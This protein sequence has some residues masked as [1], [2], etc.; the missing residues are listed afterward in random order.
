MKIALAHFRIGETDGVSLEMDKWKDVLTRMGHEVVFLA[1]SEG[2]NRAHVI[3]ELRYKH[4]LNEKF[5]YNAFEKLVDYESANDFAEDVLAFSRAIETKLTDF[6]EAEGIH[7]LVPF[8]IWSL[9]WSLP[10]GIAFA[11][12]VKTTGIR[13]LAYHHDFYWEREKYAK[14]TCS[15]VTGWLEEYF[16]PD[17][18]NVRHV[19]INRLA[20]E[21]LYRRRSIEAAVIPNVF[22]FNHPVWAE[23]EYNQSL[24]D[25]IGAS[26]DDIVIL[27]ATR[28]MERKAIELGID[29]VA[30]LQ[31]E[32]D[33]RK[34]QSASLY[35]GKKLKDE[36]RI[37]YVLAGMPESTYEYTEQLR[38]KAESLRVDLR[39]INHLIDYSRTHANGSK[40]YSLWD[41]Y[42]AADFVTYPSILE[43]WGNQLLEAVFANKPMLIYEYPVYENDIRH[44]GFRFVSLGNTHRTNADGLVSVGEEKIKAAAVRMADLLTDGEQYRS[45]VQHNFQIGKTHFSYESLLA[46]LQRIL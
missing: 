22:D 39:F 10:A 34:A 24:R 26:A 32:L 12:A 7:L 21:E 46:H 44:Y 8:N 28:V 33:A 17:L 42:V 16:P 15:F 31:K 19:V 23:D 36:S 27:Q 11:R 38:I 2:L 5:V 30:A 40:I 45:V 29:T 18:P 3:E 14:P 20:R 1:G 13:C 9:G 35:N 41:A 6:I 37:L 4:P 25:A 43:S